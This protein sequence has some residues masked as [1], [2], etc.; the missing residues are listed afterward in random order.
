VRHPSSYWSIVLLYFVSFLAFSILAVPRTTATGSWIDLPRLPC[1]LSYVPALPP[2][3]AFTATS[4]VDTDNG[5]SLVPF[6][7]RDLSVLGTQ[8]DAR[9]PN[10][11]CSHTRNTNSEFSRCLRP[12]HTHRCARDILGDTRV[13]IVA[14]SPPPPIPTPAPSLP[15]PLPLT[16]GNRL[17]STLHPAPATS[18][19][20]AREKILYKQVSALLSPARLP[21]ENRRQLPSSRPVAVPINIHATP[22]PMPCE[23]KRNERN[24]LT[25]HRM[26]MRRQHLLGTGQT[27][28]LE[29]MDGMV[30]DQRGVNILV[31]N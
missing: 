2:R 23:R 27:L 26:V 6:R 19:V 10:T 21:V 16:T 18:P 14:S 4:V 12:R 24:P 15:L 20:T 25:K 28:A 7:D 17:K 11:D 13:T 29:R 1:P 3:L 5:Y 9:S 30:Q 8:F 22:S 31:I